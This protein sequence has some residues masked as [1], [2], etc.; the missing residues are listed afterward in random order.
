[1]N[2]TG[3]PFI[4]C[5][6]DYAPS[7]IILFGAPFDGTASFRKGARFA[8]AQMRKNCGDGIETY[9]PY[10]RKDLADILVCDIGDVSLGTK[11]TSD[12]LDEI[13]KATAC[14]VQDGKLPV[15]IGG[16]H[17][18][19]L[20]A[21]R[22]LVKA[23][24]DL[25]V[26]HLDAHADLRDEMLG[27]PLSHAT[28]MRRIWDIVGDGRIFQ[29]GI[30]SG[31]RAELQWG[32]THVNTHFFNCNGIDIALKKIA[33]KPVY[34]SI[35]LDVLDSSVLPGTG[36]PEAGGIMFGDLVDAIVDTSGGAIVGAD[37]VELSPHCDPGGASTLAA[38]KAL[39]ELLLSLQ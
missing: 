22:A 34:L 13:E 5:D 6:S 4:G 21:V 26:I 11:N 12:V 25:H 31:E 35:D 7:N 37:L 17:L 20:G 28:V 19:T 36:T 39:R 2:K 1:M 14:I 38:C 33:G 10:Q 3:R 30:R 27:D 8:P 16:E 23:V 15:M 18:V 29:F 9:S 24:P 32:K